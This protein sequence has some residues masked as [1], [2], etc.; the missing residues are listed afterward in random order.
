MEKIAAIT[1]MNFLVSP[2][3]YSPLPILSYGLGMF[4]DETCVM[5]SHV[6][7]PFIELALS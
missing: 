1:K 6:R 2:S 3:F 5:S 4:A 7:I